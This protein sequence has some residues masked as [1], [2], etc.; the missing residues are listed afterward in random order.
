[1][2]RAFCR[3]GDQLRAIER[4]ISRLEAGDGADT[5]PIPA[6]FRALWNT[7]RVALATIRT[8]RMPDKRFRAEARLLPSRSSSDVPSIMFS[9]GSTARTIPSVS[10][11]SPT[12]S[13]LARRWWRA[14]SSPA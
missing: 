4:L 1:M 14:G 8:R 11:W 2:V 12:K 7:F 10:S 3:G 9:I 6:E 13:A 5:D